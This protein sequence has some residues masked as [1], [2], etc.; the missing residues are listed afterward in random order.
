MRRRIG[1][2]GVAVVLLCAASTSAG[3]ALADAHH[4]REQN[5][6]ADYLQPG[7]RTN[8]Q[9][10]RPVGNRVGGWTCY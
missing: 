7:N 8:P 5:K 1:P 10:D 9:C 3:S 4:P 2:V 6:Y